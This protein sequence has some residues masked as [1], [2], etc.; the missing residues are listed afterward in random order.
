MPLN[1]TGEAIPQPIDVQEIPPAGPIVAQPIGANAPA[2]APTPVAVGS[3]P[4][5]T[6]AP[7]DATAQNIPPTTPFL[8]FRLAKIVLTITAAS[9]LALVLYLLFMEWRIAYDVREAYHEVL[10]PDRVGAQYLVVA[11]L[12]KLSDDL[13]NV[14]QNASAQMG[15]DSLD[16]ARKVV[17]QI[18]QLPAIT[19]AQRTQLQGCV[20]PPAATDAA[21]ASKIE[22]C[23][24]LLG[25]VKQ[26][27]LQ[28]LASGT[29][30]K[31]AADSSGRIGDQ[32]EN[33]HKFWIQAAQLILLNLL[34][35][36]LTAL[37]GYIFG[38]QQVQQQP[39]KT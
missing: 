6:P 17:A 30:A 12:Q 2:V 10:T 19:T 4:P 33:L 29:D 24:I 35:P 25:A 13:G 18:V 11:Q 7:T 20:P 32:R 28:A 1:I 31:I 23:L 34:L 21:R 9:I 5:V 38:T 8:G 14:R 39:Q 15:A 3:A 36:L 26:A 22:D 16:N 37:F 27:T